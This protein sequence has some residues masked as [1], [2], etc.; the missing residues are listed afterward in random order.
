VKR[1]SV[2]DLGVAPAATAAIEKVYFPKKSKQT[3]IIEG[4]AKEAAAKLIEKLRF[5]VRAL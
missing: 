4:G 2:G 3:Q 1:F 5:E